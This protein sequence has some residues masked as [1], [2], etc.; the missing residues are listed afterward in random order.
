MKYEYGIEYDFPFGEWLRGDFKNDV[1]D[2]VKVEF[3]TRYGWSEFQDG[4]RCQVPAGIVRWRDVREFRI[5]DERYKNPS[6][7]EVFIEAALAVV[8]TSGHDC[9][10]KFILALY[11]AGF[12]APG[13]GGEA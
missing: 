11:K 8:E 1:P 12:K 10:A 4:R 6:E 9:D 7:R 5:V 3:K 13:Q 2:D